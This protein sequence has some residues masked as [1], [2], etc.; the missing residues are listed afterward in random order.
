MLCNT[1]V[2]C[3]FSV[4]MKIVYGKLGAICVVTGC[5]KF[6]ENSIGLAYAL[7]RELDIE[8]AL[9]GRLQRLHINWINHSDSQGCL[10]N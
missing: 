10:N 3:Y 4:A 5:A 2:T 6:R 8:T 9:I 1:G 7:H